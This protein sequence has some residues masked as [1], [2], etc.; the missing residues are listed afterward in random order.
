MR[1]ANDD[2]VAVRMDM[3]AD[4]S[5]VLQTAAR[6]VVGVACTFSGVFLSMTILSPTEAVT[7]V[8]ALAGPPLVALIGRRSE[9]VRPFM[10][11]QILLVALA[12]IALWCA[13]GPLSLSAAALGL[14][15]PDLATVAFAAAMTGFFV[16]VLGPIL[17]RLPAV[18]G[19]RGFDD[20]LRTLARLPVWSL[21]VAVAVG[22]IAE[23]VLY[24][25]VALAILTDAGLGSLAAA[26]RVVSAFAVAHVPLGGIGPALTTA[27]S[28]AAL[29]GFYLWHGD[30][31][32]N[33]LA[34]VATDFVGI[35]LGPLMTRRLGR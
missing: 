14:R 4:L 23:E 32:A 17:M 1:G 2:G 27:V 26:A 16:V 19:L 34:H 25:G 5:D 7:L 11:C 6:L 30:L 35:V 29:T 15:V 10:L 24:R 33:M 21:C 13:L 9:G 31:V 3:G 28:G 18:L 8:I 22:G 12:T 20:G